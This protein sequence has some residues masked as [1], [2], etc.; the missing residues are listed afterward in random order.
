MQGQ[1]RTRSKDNEFMSEPDPR[2]PIGKFTPP[3]EY[4]PD[5]RAEM[6]AQIAME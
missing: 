1:G 6:I 5:V 2:Y 4:T 3:A